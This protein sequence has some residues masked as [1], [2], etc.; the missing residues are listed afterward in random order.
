MVQ[1][2]PA[3]TPYGYPSYGMQDSLSTGYQNFGAQDSIYQMSATPNF[4]MYNT[5]SMGLADDFMYNATFN[6]GNYNNS[7]SQ[8]IYYPEEMP[9]ED[10]QPQG[11]KK[12]FFG[13]LLKWSLFGIGG[14]LLY[15]NRGALVKWGQKIFKK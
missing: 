12:G 6:G 11:K 10:Q 13:K 5:S 2:V 7:A 9:V 1:N 3:Y 15:K 8:P 14:I 4:G